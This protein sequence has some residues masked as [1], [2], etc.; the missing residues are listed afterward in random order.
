MGRKRKYQITSA[1]WSEK[2][3]GKL[4]NVANLVWLKLKA[5]TGKCCVEGRK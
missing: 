4:P 5:Y 2:C 3:W 1:Q